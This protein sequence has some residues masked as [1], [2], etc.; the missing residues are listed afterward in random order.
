[1]SGSQPRRGILAQAVPHWTH[2]PSTQQATASQTEDRD[3]LMG[4]GSTATSAPH[5]G[6]I[7]LCQQQ[8]TGYITSSPLATDVYKQPSKPIV[9]NLKKMT[10]EILMLSEHFSFHMIGHLIDE[11]EN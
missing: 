11:K 4:A 7:N 10:L 9:D 5:T 6:Q 2:R 8:V 1:M 3:G